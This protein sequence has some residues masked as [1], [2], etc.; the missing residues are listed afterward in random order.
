MAVE[1]GFGKKVD[2]ELLE[3]I[4]KGVSYS[5]PSKVYLALL[6]GL[7]AEQRG[8]TP[9]QFW[10]EEIKT[11]EAGGYAR[12]EVKSNFGEAAKEATKTAPAELKNSTEITAYTFAGGG[13]TLATVKAFVLTTAATG[14]SEI[15]G[16]GT[17]TEVKIGELYTPA[18]IAVGGLKLELG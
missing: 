9:A 5:A 12:V 4:F 17:V 16:F 15:L 3:L 13:G 2:K 14:E 10:A 1:S 18:K 7:P 8:A 6:K 11:S